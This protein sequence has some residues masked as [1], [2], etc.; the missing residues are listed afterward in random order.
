MYTQ[1]LFVQDL[2]FRM[3][4]IPIIPEMNINDVFSFKS[5]S[6]FFIERDSWPYQLHKE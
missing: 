4:S 2:F 6:L 1:I 5:W 3:M